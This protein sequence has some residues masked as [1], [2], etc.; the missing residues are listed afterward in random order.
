MLQIDKPTWLERN[1]TNIIAGACTV[2]VA[3]VLGTLIMAVNLSMTQA[4]TAQEIRD[5]TIQ[6][7]TNA[8]RIEADDRHKQIGCKKATEARARNKAYW[9]TFK[10]REGETGGGKA[11]TN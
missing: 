4:H 10:A 11:K 3:S 8:A 1:I 9:Q 5:L 6:T 7:R 2:I